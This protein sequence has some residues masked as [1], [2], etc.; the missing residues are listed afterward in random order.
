MNESKTLQNKLLLTR[1][2]RKWIVGIE[3]YE[4]FNEIREFRITFSFPSLNKSYSVICEVNAPN[5]N[6]YF[7]HV[8]VMILKLTVLV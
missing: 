4:K 2:S 6:C 7:E 8:T 3:K 1:K 5:M